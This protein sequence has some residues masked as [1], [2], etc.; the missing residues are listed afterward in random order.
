MS[1]SSVGSD[2]PDD[3][4][5]SGDL[6]AQLV[7][8]LGRDPLARRERGDARRVGRR[9]LGGDAPGGLRGA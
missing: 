3:A 6:G 1:V 5:A 2:A 7:E 9:D 4:G 8:Q